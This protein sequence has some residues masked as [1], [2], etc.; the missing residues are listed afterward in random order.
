MKKFICA[1]FIAFC[2]MGVASIITIA[3]AANQHAAGTTFRDSKG[4]VWFISESNCKAAYTSAGAFVSYGYNNWSKVIQGNSSD[5][6]LRI[7]NNGETHDLRGFIAPQNGQIICSDRDSDRG[8]CY[9]IVR[10]LKV[11][12]PSEYVFKRL[13]FSFDN[14]PNG[15]LSWISGDAEY[16]L[17]NENQPHL[18]GV[19]INDN[20]TI[21]L[22]ELSENGSVNTFGIPDMKTFNSWGYNLNDVVAANSYDRQ[23][24]ASGQLL[25][26]RR[27]GQIY[28]YGMGNFDQQ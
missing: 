28:M 1:I 16:N 12:F 14:A 4:T 20:G 17:N 10:G 15:D 18:P 8:T 2:G 21:K 3:Q 27:S 5:I 22:I 6:S 9:L 24:S 11:G 26:I 25:N 13:G 19:L 23:L 7:C